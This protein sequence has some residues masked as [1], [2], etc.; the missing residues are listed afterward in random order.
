[1]QG[2][3][4]VS[5][6]H[7]DTYL[8]YVAKEGTH[9]NRPSTYQ[10]DEKKLQKIIKM[11]A[12]SEVWNCPTM[13]ITTRHAGQKSQLENNPNLKYVSP[14]MKSW[15]TSRAAGLNNWE[16]ANYMIHKNR[17]VRELYRAGAKMI[18]GVDTGLRYLIP[19]F[20]VHEELEN[21]VKAGIPN[22]AALQMAT[23]NGATFLGTDDLMG[24]VEIGK[25]ADLLIL[26]KNPLENIKNTREIFA[27][28]RG[29]YWLSKGYLQNRLVEIAAEY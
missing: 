19:G 23:I 8:E 14:R 13:T 9:I 16:S 15:Y 20:T 1:M 18:L 11:T 3:Y 25:K 28:T 7:I 22:L 27:V 6:E 2:N 17:L 10:M 5:I 21:L 24:S 29:E 4:Q 26:N 12:Q